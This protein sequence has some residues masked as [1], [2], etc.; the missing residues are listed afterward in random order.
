[1]PY[2]KDTY[3]PYIVKQVISNKKPVTEEEFIEFAQ[4]LYDQI[5]AKEKS[6]TQQVRN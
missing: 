1:M 2:I 5:K 3:I 4:D 6:I